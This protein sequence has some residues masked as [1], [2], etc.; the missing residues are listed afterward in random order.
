MSSFF[1]TVSPS[2]E[3]VLTDHVAPIGSFSRLPA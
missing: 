3:A 2:P 1:P